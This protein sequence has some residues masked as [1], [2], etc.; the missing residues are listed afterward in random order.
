MKINILLCILAAY[1]AKLAIFSS[2]YCISFFQKDTLAWYSE[3]HI[4]DKEV[5]KIPQEQTKT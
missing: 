3:L 4:F 2:Q 5:P 1:V